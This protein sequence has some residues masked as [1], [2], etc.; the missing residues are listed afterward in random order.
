M[1]LRDSFSYI[2]NKK[3]IDLVSNETA[4]EY[5]STYSCPF[6]DQMDPI[7]YQCYFWFPWDLNFNLKNL[8]IT[9]FSIPY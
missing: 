8:S 4:F 1:D 9:S 7:Q 5:Y 3:S 2:L 6:K